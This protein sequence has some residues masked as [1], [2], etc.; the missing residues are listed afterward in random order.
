[1]RAAL[2]GLALSLLAGC[3]VATH[4]YKHRYWVKQDGME[5]L[6]PADI[7]APP[8]YISY[9]LLFER[10]GLF[11]AVSD[12]CEAYPLDVRVT[13]RFAPATNPLVSILWIMVSGSSVFLV[14]Y[15][16]QTGITAE[17]TVSVD[18]KD[19]RTFRYTDTKTTWLSM[20]AF[21]TLGQETDEYYVEELIADQFVN[22]FILDLHQDAELLA[23]VRA[24]G[25]PA[26]P[27]VATVDAP[28]D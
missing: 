17:F 16:G 21:A 20:F 22:S 1:M 19:L 11:A 25:R 15:R 6:P 8:G 28:A 14:P 5:A 9:P 4:E 12:N 7:H 13:T 26:V 18:G 24:S 2:A 3:S 23:Q 27:A 10:K